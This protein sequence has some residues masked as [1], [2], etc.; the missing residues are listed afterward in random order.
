MVPTRVVSTGAEAT[1]AAS[2][3]GLP[4]V[5]KGTARGLSHKSDLGLV[6][7]GLRT[8]H[9]VATAFDEVSATLAAQPGTED[10]QVLAQP[11]VGS[12]IE[13][14]VGVR[15]DPSFG[16]VLVVGVGGILVEILKDVS[17]R[18]GVVDRQGALEMLGETAAGK[19][20][21]GVRG[22]GPYDLDAA[23]AVIARL[24]VLGV[25]SRGLLKSIEIN[26]LIVLERG[27]GA[28]GVDVLIE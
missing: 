23:A 14:I 15:N 7:V 12:G 2:E 25:A 21:A 20:L 27:S 26:P 6:R 17:V 18:L 16:T 22:A 28:L 24:S 5:L 9:E 11:M 1:R 8:T 4:L 13:L 3:L 19:L 10:A